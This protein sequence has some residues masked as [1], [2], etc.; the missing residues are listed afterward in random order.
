MSPG[1]ARGARVEHDRLERRRFDGF[2]FVARHFFLFLHIPRAPVGEPAV[3]R[4]GRL[5]LPAGVRA[6]GDHGERASPRE[7]RCDRRRRAFQRGG[8]TR[9]G[10]RRRRAKEAGGVSPRRR[11][12]NRLPP[13]RHARMPGTTRGT[14]RT[15]RAPPRVRPRRF[16]S[17]SPFSLWRGAFFLVK[18]LRLRLSAPPVSFPSPSRLSSCAPSA[19]ASRPRSRNARQSAGSAAGIAFASSP[20]GDF[21]AKRAARGGR[22]RKRAEP[23]RR[24]GG[25]ARAAAAAASATRS[26]DTT[27][28]SIAVSSRPTFAVRSRHR[29]YARSSATRT[30]AVSAA[31]PTPRSSVR[32]VSVAAASIC[33]AT[34]RAAAASNSC[35]RNRSSTRSTSPTASRA[36]NRSSRETI[37]SGSK[38][39]RKTRREDSRAPPIVEPT[40]APRVPPARAREQRHG[41]GEAP[42]AA[43]GG[44]G[45][46]DALT[47]GIVR[48]GEC[49]GVRGDVSELARA[50]RQQGHA[51]HRHVRRDDF[52]SRFR[53]ARRRRL[54]VPDVRSRRRRDS[55]PDEHAR[56]VGRRRRVLHDDT[57][58][59]FGRVFS[60]RVVLRGVASRQQVFPYP[61]AARGCQVRAPQGYDPERGQRDGPARV[62]AD[63]HGESVRRVEVI[64]QRRAK[65]VRSAR[66]G[67]PRGRAAPAALLRAG[68][69]LGGS[70]RRGGASLVRER[71]APRPTRARSASAGWS[72]RARAAC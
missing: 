16:R 27:A 70:A 69:R 58:R 12:R 52:V 40:R 23:R 8:R 28:A 19:S 53:F 25:D 7:A 37:P 24:L 55:E 57:T 62:A 47:H 2:L 64:H 61:R 44:G 29:A 50:R 56:E 51:R 36:M 46:G 22:A 31:G 13:P 32:C 6:G 14:P 34:R 48:G 65:G 49:G 30:L 4:L 35:D 26:A 60:F 39:R 15:R 66:L 10:T 11:A 20:S 21:P 41:L 1:G 5:R 54:V 71:R 43:P 67:A 72:P 42:R 33:L 59:A 3:R 9:R 17:G 38:K 68:L 45:G 18:N 63:Q